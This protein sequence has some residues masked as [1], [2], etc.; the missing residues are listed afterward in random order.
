MIGE[1]G[2]HIGQLF[3]GFS[4]LL[5]SLLVGSRPGF[6]GQLAQADA[7]ELRGEA[8]KARAVLFEQVRRNPL[9]V[10]ALG[11]LAQF[12]ERHN[13]PATEEVYLRLLERVQDPERRRWIA[14]RL[15]LHALLRGDRQAA[16]RYL[17][18]YREAGGGTVTFP[19]A[20]VEIPPGY[21]FIEIPGP[22]ESFARMAAISPY[23]E[24]VEVLPAVAR[25]VVINGYR[26]VASYQGLEPT[27]YLKL[28]KRYVA[29]ARELQQLAGNEQVITIESCDSAATG[30]LL[31]VLGYRMRGRCGTELVLETVNATRAFLTIDSGFPLAELEQALR[32]NRPFR[33]P[34]R[35]TRIPILYGVEYWLG[36]RQA[37]PAT[38]IDAFLDDPALC[39]VYMAMAKLDPETAEAL[40]RAVPLEKLSAFAHVLDFYGGM[41]QIR[42]GKAITP[43]GP[44][45]RRVWRRLV[46]E[47][48]DKGAEF[49]AAL[50]ARDDGWLASFFDAL[51]RIDG[52]VREYLTQPQRLE[53][54]YLAIRGKVT[55]PG[56]ARPVFR[57]NSEMVLLISRLWLDPDGSP[58]IPGNLEIWKGL[59]AREK[60]EV[61]GKRLQRWAPTWKEPDDLLEALFA[62]CRRAVENEPLKLFMLLSDLDRGRRVPLQASTVQRLVEMYPAY[63]AQYR[64]FAET[65]ELTDEAI[66]KFLDVAATIDRIDDRM[67]RANVAGSFQA[68]VGLWQ[69]LVRDG[70]LGAEQASEQFVGLMDRFAKV[71][72]AVSL[73]DAA[74]SGLEHL[75][76]AT[77][78]R[79]RLNLHDRILDLLAGVPA[80]VDA[81]VHR[82]LVEHLME[83]FEAQKL[84]PA[85]ALIE[86]ARHLEAV[87][88][89]E[90]LD[91]P[92]L[93]RISTRLE[94][95]QPYWESIS[96]VERTG[97]SHGYWVERHIQWQRRLDLVQ[98][99]RRALGS[100]Q[101]LR[102]L[103]GQLA[104]L[105][106]DTLVGYNY[107][108]YAPPG[109]QVIRTNP[110]FVRSHDFIGSYGTQSTWAS[111]EVL[112]TGWPSNAGGRL[113]G[114]LVNL[115]YALAQG[116]QNFLVPE[117]EPALIWT[118]LVPQMLVTSRIA[119]WWK[120]SPA[121]VEWVALH[122]QYGRLSLAEAA[123]DEQR[124]QQ[125]IEVLAQFGLP[126]EVARVAYW[127]EQGA[128]D[129]ALNHVTPTELFMFARRLVQEE[130]DPSDPLARRI[131]QL[132]AREPAEINYEAVSRT[133]GTPKPLLRA[134]YRPQLLGLRR[135]PTL[136]GYSSRILAESWEANL[137][138][139]ATL[140]HELYLRPTQLNLVVPEWTR[141][142]VEKIFATHLEDWRA[143]WRSLQEAGAVIAAERRKELGEY[144]QASLN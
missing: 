74:A 6:A 45:A 127:L 100:P 98:E 9:D 138:Y 17:E 133:F 32:T 83:L 46:G 29:Q 85:D 12:L 114:S 3:L 140:A 53:R 137:L 104:P 47:D 34:Y 101:R 1:R 108:F 19:P 51:L 40:R 102:A 66:L 48:P 99:A 82:R 36:S 33:Y 63:G 143:V 134:S 27:E 126:G 117:A 54:F 35:P 119:R 64:I 57:A 10:S 80:Q 4:C 24:P 115:P 58:H 41:F 79:G 25:N 106:R 11:E 77:G 73:F 118:D 31:R 60:G 84:I 86:A 43:G 7:L 15:A 42:Q 59:F 88:Q 37:S 22:L 135:F 56:P 144:L 139:F 72:D 78:A 55:S 52:P 141:L 65:P 128:P 50:I 142:A 89:G 81:E 71:N 75:I 109:A 132:A 103:R 76:A 39:R 111:T 120:L 136:M 105:L 44:E 123:I 107:L 129:R 124:R 130:R 21:G 87:A 70:V 49:F 90:K 69:I 125:V 20:P 68:L 5:A 14:R 116:E 110:L 26:A 131:Q 112:A 23:L 62:Y 121:L 28:L 93:A 38:A 30:D 96:Q 122:I 8:L 67:L 2:E 61:Y 16:G 18:L 92:L 113:V 91:T 13:D 95:V 97:L 94:E